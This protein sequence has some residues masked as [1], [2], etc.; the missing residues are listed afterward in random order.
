VIEG[1]KPVQNFNHRIEYG[2]M[3]HLCE[4]ELASGGNV[5]KELKT[6]ARGLCKKYPLQQE[7]IVH[8]YEVC[9]VQFPVYV[10][11]WAKDKTQKAKEEIL[12]EENFCVPYTLP[13]GRVVKLRG[14]WDGVFWVGS[15]R[16]GGLYLNEHKTKGDIKEEQLRRQLQFDLQTMLYL[17]ALREEITHNRQ[18]DFPSGE[19]KGILYNVVRRPL[20]GGK[21]SIRL[22]KP[23]KAK[24]RGEPRGA[25]YARL[26]GLI[27]EEPE[28]YFMRWQVDVT[29]ED[30]KRFEREFLIPILESLCEWWDW[31]QIHGK[32]ASNYASQL[33]GIHWRTPYGIWN[34]LAEGGS[35]E[36]DEYLSSGSMLGLERIGNLFPELV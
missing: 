22:H 25:F 4:E 13:S 8:W 11:Y 1:L 32:D 33:T 21:H 14:R 5:Y 17:V 3:W 35:T 31:M 27:A 18:D 19:I 26:G 29:N 23:S 28:H 7:Q 15:K 6:Y 12:Q 34:P 16:K 20:A 36:M 9:K 24:P 30:L 2:N 10:K